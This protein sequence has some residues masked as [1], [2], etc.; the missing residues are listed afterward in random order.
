M[1]LRTKVTLNDAANSSYEY[2]VKEGF[3]LIAPTEYQTLYSYNAD[4]QF[5][6]LSSTTCVIWAFAYKAL[7]KIIKG[8]LITVWFYRDGEI[9]FYIHRPQK[10]E[11]S[12]AEIIDLLYNLS[13]AC[14]LKSLKIWPI[15]KRFLEEFK[16]VTGYNIET[17]Y[18][19]NMSEYRYLVSDFIQLEGRKNMYKRKRLKKLFE[20]NS[21]I[22]FKIL[23]KDNFNY[24]FDI[25]DDWCKD[26]DCKICDDFGNGCAKDSLIQMH[27]I[28][29]ENIHSGI[30]GFIDNKPAGYAI[31]DKI[32]DDTYIAYYSKATVQNLN[33]LLYYTMVKD[34]MQD[35]KYLNIGPDMGKEG[36]RNFKQHLSEYEMQ[37]KY[38]CTFK[39]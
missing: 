18:S 26:Q 24:C 32:K 8:Y 16:S 10:L 1:E 36:L 37:D 2:L 9:F 13:L 11:C 19:E 21:N 22:E 30:I 39:K 35:A 23:S 38:L 29:D 6:E 15:E 4:N 7:Y 12:I 33:M 34:H 28:F 27:A 31:W 5:H 25:E 17:V 14:G 20:M 3:K